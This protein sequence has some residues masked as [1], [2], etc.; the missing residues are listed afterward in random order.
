MDFLFADDSKQRKP[1]RNGMGQLVGVGGIHVPGDNVYQLEKSLNHICEG[2]SLPK[3]EEFKWSPDSNMWMRRNLIGEDRFNFFQRILDKAL[4]HEVKAY[5]VIVDAN[6][7]PAIKH[8]DSEMDAVVLLLERFHNALAKET[9]GLVI[10]DRPQGG[11]KD[12]KNFLS[13]SYE[14]L[15]EGTP[16]VQFDRIALSILTSPS[17]YVRLLQL[18]DLIVGCSMA[19]VGGED[20]Y[21]P[22]IFECIKPLLAKNGGIVSGVGLKIHPDYRYANLYHWLLGDDFLVRGLV[23]ERLPLPCRPYNSDPYTP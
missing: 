13:D 11:P 8:L 16:Y 23:G 9:Q 2:F 17:K 20:T 12:Q 7:K 4:Q 22:R 14:R 5:V 15:K 10:V 21:S 6:Y 19:R 1:S 18:A 3:G